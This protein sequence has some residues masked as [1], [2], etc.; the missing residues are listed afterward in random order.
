MLKEGDYTAHIQ[1][2]TC[3]RVE[4]FKKYR[5]PAG[6]EIIIKHWRHRGGGER[7]PH[8]AN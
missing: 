1:E 6:V 3:K 7:G 2:H 4:N 8:P 5:N